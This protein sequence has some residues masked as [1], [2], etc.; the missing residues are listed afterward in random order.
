MVWVRFDDGFPEHP[1][2]ARVGA[3]GAWLHIQA[4]S[5]SNRNLTDG[6][7][8]TNEL[9]KFAV[10]GTTVEDPDGSVW[11]LGLTSGCVG[12][13]I[14]EVP[15]TARMIEAGLWE[16]APG[17]IRVHD[18]HLYQPR[19]EDVVARREAISKIRSE[20]GRKG[21]EKTNA[22]RFGNVGK[23]HGKT[24]ANAE[25]LPQQSSTANGPENKGK[26]RQTRQTPQQTPR[27]THAPGP[28]PGPVEE[29]NQGEEGGVRGEGRFAPPVVAL[30]APSAP[31]ASSGVSFQVAGKG[32]KTWSPPDDLVADLVR[33]YPGVDVPYELEKAAAKIR[34]R[35]VSK[36]SARGMSR[37]LHSWMER[38][39]N[40][41]PRPAPNGAP[42][43]ARVPGAPSR[44]PGVT[45]APDGS[46]LTVRGER[47]DRHPA[48]ERRGI[49]G[50]YHS[51]PN[52][53]GE[54]GGFRLDGS[55]PQTEAKWTPTEYVDFFRRHGI[56]G[57]PEK[58]ITA[59]GCWPSAM[60]EPAASDSPEKTPPLEVQR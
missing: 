47:Y 35:A 25:N 41:A 39:Q 12:K 22:I 2:I 38:A 7:V 13:D 56:P 17:G 29:K 44:P 49:A 58:L 26:T 36:K 4:V 53:L 19:K 15:W 9:G 27:Q 57:L 45:F 48:F 20:V 43:P 55:S 40:A 11:S 33:L 8:P 52:G 59:I 16:P 3:F 50:W 21:A 51:A 32:P 5:Y 31:S 54:G 34:A 23:P 24:T 30:E 10:S 28:V 1:K 14:G 37:F 6:F 60:K 18:F 46:W 42:G